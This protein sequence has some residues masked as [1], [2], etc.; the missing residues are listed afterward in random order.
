M[1]NRIYLRNATCS[2]CDAAAASAADRP[3][4]IERR[5]PVAETGG[6]VRGLLDRARPSLHVRRKSAQGR[7][8]VLTTEIKQ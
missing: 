8:Y 1:F 3:L 5:A 2:G 4:G 7:H 6:A